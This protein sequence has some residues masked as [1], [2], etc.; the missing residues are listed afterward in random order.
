MTPPSPAP[1][2]NTA[3][4]WTSAAA[5]DLAAAPAL[6]VE[7]VEV[8]FGTEAG[9]RHVTFTV[10][11]GKRLAV[12]GP[13]GAGKTSLLRAVAGLA[14]M[15]SGRITV[16][17]RDVSTLPPN[18]RDA[19]YLHQT[20]VLFPHLTVA[21]NIAFPLQ[22][23]GT[24]RADTGS[25]VAQHLDVLQITG[26]ASRYPHELSGGQRQRVALA[27]AMA[28]RPAVL[29]LDEPLAALDPALR[30]DVRDAMVATQELHAAAIVLVTH[31]LTDAAALGDDI[32]VLLNGT[33]AQ[34]ATP[35]ALFSA[36]AS[37]AVARFLGTMHELPGYVRDNLL[38]GEWGSLPLKSAQLQH[39]GNVVAVLPRRAIRV[40]GSGSVSAT[41]EATRLTPDGPLLL[42]RAG[43]A[44][45]AIPGDASALGNAAH[46]DAGSHVTL[47]VDMA[48]ATIFPTPE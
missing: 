1:A 16:R 12:L 6:R 21:Q 20:P 9:L 17:G 36:P 30:E 46:R 32:L 13:S 48:Q 39:T 47:D 22:V 15:S 10:A 18:R 27:R 45:L 14:P 34:Q 38:H 29:L 24:A 40:G 33:V 4:A 35:A 19:V 31:D 11:Q 25:I 43:S 23:R 8:P 7:D 5:E 2:D 28:A 44:R 42:V 41:I 26:L 37:L 3:T